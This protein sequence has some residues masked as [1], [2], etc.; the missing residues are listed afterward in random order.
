VV[1]ISISRQIIDSTPILFGAEI[2]VRPQM[3]SKSDLDSDEMNSRFR[4]EFEASR[5]VASAFCVTDAV[6]GHPR[7]NVFDLG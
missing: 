1:K 7:A 3:V 2:H 6:A 4:N 5:I